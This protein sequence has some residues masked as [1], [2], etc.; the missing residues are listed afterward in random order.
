MLR[1]KINNENASDKIYPSK[2]NKK[3]TSTYNN[4]IANR[5][6]TKKFLFVTSVISFIIFVYFYLNY[7]HKQEINKKSDLPLATDAERKNKVFV[8]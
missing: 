5:E 7:S 8:K 2:K 6:N 1:K 3:K 4:L